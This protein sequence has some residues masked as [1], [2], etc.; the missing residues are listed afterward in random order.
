MTRSRHPVVEERVE[1]GF[2][3]N[4]IFL[5]GEDNRFII[6]TGPNMAGKSTYMRQ[7]ALN[8]IMAQMGSFIPADEAVIGMVD[9]IFTRVGASDDLVRG[10]STF[11]VE[12]LELANIR[13]NNSV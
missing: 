13:E 4:D 11:M 10:Q 8:V 12:M 9:R 6:L 2:V 1:W 5:D 7:A 3:P